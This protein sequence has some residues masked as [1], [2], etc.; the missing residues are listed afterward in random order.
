M[1]A[2]F[3]QKVTSHVH[4]KLSSTGS[5]SECVVPRGGAILACR[6]PLG[7]GDGPA[8]AGHLGQASCRSYAALVLSGFLLLVTRSYCVTSA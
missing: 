4:S 5:Y 1:K 8:E 3:L 2:W 6:E 7:G